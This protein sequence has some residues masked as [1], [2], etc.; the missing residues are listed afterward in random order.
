M[1]DAMV[2]QIVSEGVR[3]ALEEGAR[4]APDPIDYLRTAAA[5]VERVV[6]VLETARPQEGASLRAILAEEVVATARSLI[7]GRQN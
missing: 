1:R 5:E 4:A 7:S 3:A 6:A 2:R